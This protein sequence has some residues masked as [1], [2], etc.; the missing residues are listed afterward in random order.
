MIKHYNTIRRYKIV[1]AWPTFWRHHHHHHHRTKRLWWRAV[2]WLREHR[3]KFRKSFVSACDRTPN[4]KL[5][6]TAE[7]IVQDSFWR[8]VQSSGSS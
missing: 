1:S 7:T 4:Q 2:R 3:T 8:T 6:D 5:S